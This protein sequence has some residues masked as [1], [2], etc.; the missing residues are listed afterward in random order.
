MS[1]PLYVDA[2]TLYRWREL[3]PVGIVRLERLIAAHLR[4]RS[5]LG[6]VQFVLWERGYRPATD[7]ETAQ[8]DVLLRDVE[9]PGSED[10]SPLSGRSDRRAEAA[11]PATDAAATGSRSWKQRARRLALRTI[12]RVPDH[13]RPFAEQAAWS[14]ATLAVESRR[15]AQ[16]AM[17]ER[18]TRPT[19]TRQDVAVHH[20]ID[21][22]RGGDLVALGLG[23]EYID[24]EAMYRLKTDHGF[25]IHMPGFDLIPV[26]MPQ[27]NA[28]Q[29][30]LVHRFYAEMAHYADTITSISEA[31]TAELRRFFREEMLP[32]VHLATNPLPGFG[33]TVGPTPDPT[34]RR[35]RF[36]D[37]PFVLT[38]STIEI[39][40]NHVLLAKVWAECIREGVELPQLAIVG[41]VG[42]DVDELM[43][44]VHHAP[45]LQGVVTINTDVDDDELAAMYEDALFTVFP[46]RIEGW[47]LPVTESLEAGT[48]CLHATDPAQFEAAQGLMP[49]LHPD[50]FLGWKR[51]IL[52]MATDAGH[53]DGLTRLINE[54]YVCTTP[55]E[56]CRRYESILAGRRG[57]ES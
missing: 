27:M 51:E 9:H 55:D 13:L 21:L 44:W 52:R 53:R 3:A 1:Q 38:V 33:R 6:P 17:S 4:H 30:H 8:L 19:I 41:R 5:G 20:T 47:G 48:P 57:V 7:A 28:G 26:T 10:R 18:R 40:K 31:T 23:W 46:S 43:R 2:T 24:H 29:S 36:A 35:H 11:L 16:R 15:Y 32:E 12:D 37:E 45:E 50:D 22:S 49:A 54:R 14:T 34:V 39:R 42:W 56:Y 25:R